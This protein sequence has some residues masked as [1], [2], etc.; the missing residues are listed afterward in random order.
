[1]WELIRDWFVDTYERNKLI[2]E[3]NKASKS[4]FISGKSKTLLKSKITI[5]KKSYGHTFSRLFSGF[6]LKVINGK[7]LTKSELIE[8]SKVILDNEQ[9]VRKLMT[10]GWDTLEIHGSEDSIGLRWELKKYSKIGKV[11]NEY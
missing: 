11:I 9:I 3:F 5:G 2:R 7:D 6:R 10:L 8:V 4:S 1:M